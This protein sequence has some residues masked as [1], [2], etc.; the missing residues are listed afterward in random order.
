MSPQAC[1]EDVPARPGIRQGDAAITDK[2]GRGRTPGSG[3]VDF[4]FAK[5]TD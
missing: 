2:I 4:F 3:R 1:R 5:K